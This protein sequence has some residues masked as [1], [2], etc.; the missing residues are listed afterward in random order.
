MLA[1]IKLAIYY[2]VIYNL[3]HSRYIGFCN[4]LRVWYVSKIIKIAKYDKRSKIEPRVYI[5]NGEHM[6]I[7]QNCRINENVFIQGA[8]IGDNVLIAPNV[9]ILSVSH[10]HDDVTIPIVEQGETEPDPPKIGNGVWL[11]RN[12]VVLKGVKIGDNSIV[13]AGAIVTKDVAPNTIVGGVPARLI[14]N[15]Q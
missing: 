15:R 1:R 13:A 14:K 11:G 7:G 10:I 6:H 12:V 3:P 8:I 9:A 5:S 2:A 4:S